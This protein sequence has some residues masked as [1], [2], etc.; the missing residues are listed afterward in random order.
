[1]KVITDSS[2]I[3]QSLKPVVALGNF[4]GVHLGHQEVIK[5]AVAL[6][7]EIQVP[8]MVLTFNPNP[9]S[10][11]RPS[12]FKNISDIKTKYKCIEELGVDY[13]YEINFDIPFS[14]LSPEEFVDNI[15]IEKLSLSHLVTGYNFHFGKNKEGNF[16][17]MNE[18]SKSKGF[19]YSVIR[20]VNIDNYNISS[21]QI[22]N[23]IKSARLNLASKLLGR[24]FSVNAKVIH[25]SETLGDLKKIKL[26]TEKSII[27]PKEG[28]Y[29]AKIKNT[30]LFVIALIQDS[31]TNSFEIILLEG[32]IS[33]DCV[34]VEILSLMR[35]FVKSLDKNEI[36][37]QLRRDLR[38]ADYLKGNFKQKSS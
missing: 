32:S 19:K 34:D 28:V 31:D 15:L 33:S 23:F 3:D 2:I 37:Y 24:I 5:T 36:E 12:I 13:I 11:F 4:D 18:Y 25:S 7:K 35:P 21:S 14:K 17:S 6:A 1:M 8:S 10:I 30:E 38:D 9:A 16:N 29:L 20:E 22:R 27:I 26:E